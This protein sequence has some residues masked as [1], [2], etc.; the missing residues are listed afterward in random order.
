MSLDDQALND[1]PLSVPGGWRCSAAQA[2]FALTARSPVSGSRGT[3]TEERMAMKTG[4]SALAA[5]IARQFQLETGYASSAVALKAA[6]DDSLALARLLAQG[7]SSAAVLL[8]DEEVLGRL[9]SPCDWMTPLL[10][11]RNHFADE[12]S[13]FFVAL[14]TSPKGKGILAALHRLRARL[15]AQRVERLCNRDGIGFLGMVDILPRRAIA[16]RTSLFHE[17][18]AAVIAHRLASA[19]FFCCDAFRIGGGG[20]HGSSQYQGT[21]S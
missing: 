12:G 14:T 16:P 5:N 8:M 7:G 17:R 1:E 4:S 15:V 6:P 2:L 21:L 13:K 9:L 18:I 10:R 11:V 3:P 19:T 20:P